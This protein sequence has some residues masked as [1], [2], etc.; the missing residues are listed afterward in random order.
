MEM[1]SVLIQQQAL[2]S[3]GFLSF[4]VS[5]GFSKTNLFNKWFPDDTPRLRTKRFQHAA[6]IWSTVFIIHKTT[7]FENNYHY[8]IEFL[9]PK[10]NVVCERQRD[11]RWIHCTNLWSL[12]HLFLLPHEKQAIKCVQASASDSWGAW[13]QRLAVWVWSWIP[14]QA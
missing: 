1:D 10:Q 6:A 9:V 14:L 7:K 12:R 3:R 13:W 4:N 5:R 8:N 2:K 11:K